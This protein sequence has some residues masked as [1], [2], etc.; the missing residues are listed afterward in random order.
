M[1]RGLALVAAT[2]FSNNYYSVMYRGISGWTGVRGVKGAVALAV[3]PADPTESD[4]FGS[5]VPV[6]GTNG[7]EK[8]LILMLRADIELGVNTTSEWAPPA[9]GPSVPNGCTAFGD[10]M[11]PRSIFPGEGAANLTAQQN[12]SC[13]HRTANLAVIA[14]FVRSTALWHGNFTTAWAKMVTM[15]YAASE[16]CAVGDTSAACTGAS[17]AAAAADASA[18]ISGGALAGAVVG[19]VVGTAALTSAAWYFWGRS[20]VRGRGAEFKSLMHAEEA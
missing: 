19:A 14:D 12:A 18:G 3:N 8:G 1:S 15:G 2:S 20:A 17:P 7:T 4:E 13:P 11:E 6:A 9:G 5:Y 10:L 16:L